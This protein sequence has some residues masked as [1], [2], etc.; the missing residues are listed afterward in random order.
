MNGCDEYYAGKGLYWVVNGSSGG[1]L[2]MIKKRKPTH[3]MAL[4]EP[5]TDN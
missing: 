4:P 2:I 3:W 5:P 1:G